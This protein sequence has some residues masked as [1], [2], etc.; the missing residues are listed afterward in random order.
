MKKS[1]DILCSRDVIVWRLLR[2]YA[3]LLIGLALSLCLASCTS[4]TVYSE[5]QDVPHSGWAADSAFSFT[6]DITD[7]LSA[8]DLLIHVRHTQQYPYQNMWLFVEGVTPTGSGTDTIEFYLADQRGQWL[9][10]GWGNLREMP[11]LYMH[12][13]TFPAS[14]SY[15]CRIS[16]G[17]RDETLRGINDIGLT[18][19]TIK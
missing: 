4:R 13:V 18:I 10:N 2:G 14:G 17:M 19:E 9:G 8:Y 11:V 3:I 5:F 15:T 12:N 1:L 7:T 16:Q 6:F